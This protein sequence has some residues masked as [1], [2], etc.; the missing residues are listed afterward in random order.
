MYRLLI[1]DDE[2]Q[3]REGLKLLLP[4]EEYG[5]EI[6]G[7]AQN[8]KEALELM[9]RLS[10]HIVLLD[11]QMPVMNGYEASRAIRALDRG[12]VTSLPI[13]A[14][15]ADAFEEDVRNAKRAGMDRHFAK[16]IDVKAFEQMLYE[17]LLGNP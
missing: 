3:I 11:I 17:Y 12:D 10:P 1:V 15:T 7:E 5:I 14:M 8:G 4:W 16:P 9:E 6:C 2:K 13:I